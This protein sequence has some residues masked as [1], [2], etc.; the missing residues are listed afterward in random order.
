MICPSCGRSVPDGSRYCSGCG[1][2]L[3][4]FQNGF[5]CLRCGARMTTSKGICPQCGAASTSASSSSSS[6]AARVSAYSAASSVSGAAASAFTA[7]SEDSVTAAVSASADSASSSSAGFCVDT[8]YGSV[9]ANASVSS[10]GAAPKGFQNSGSRKTQIFCHSRLSSG[11]GSPL[12]EDFQEKLMNQI[13]NARQNYSAKGSNSGNG[14]FAFESRSGNGQSNFR[15][16]DNNGNA[17]NGG[18]LPEGFWENFGNMFKTLFP[19]N[20]NSSAARPSSE[21]RQQRSRFNSAGSEKFS[22]RFRDNVR[23]SFQD[24]SQPDNSRNRGGGNTRDYARAEPEDS[25]DDVFQI[26]E[27]ELEKILRKYEI[28]KEE[29]EEM[30]RQ[31]EIPEEELEEM[32]RQDEIPEEEL[33]EMLRQDEIP[34]EELEEMLHQD[35]ISKEELEELLRQGN[36]EIRRYFNEMKGSGNTAGFDRDHNARGYADNYADDY[37]DDYPKNR[38]GN[39]ASGGRHESRQKKDHAGNTRGFTYWETEELRKLNHS[40]DTAQIIMVLHIIFIFVGLYFSA[41]SLGYLAFTAPSKIRQAEYFL[42][43]CGYPESV[44]LCRR[45]LKTMIFFKIVSV[46]MALGLIVMIVISVAGALKIQDYSPDTVSRLFLFL[47]VF[48]LISLPFQVRSFMTFSGI[49]K[50]LKN[51]TPPK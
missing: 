14:S 8:Q 30:L 23:N 4:H 32:L 18:E 37:R 10:S 42:E 17:N 41:L 28:P 47:F 7:A 2:D 3:R 19:Q 50:D 48:W 31:D 5:F 27:E 34:E 51:L 44:R 39:Y 35:K 12:P 25:F 38:A 1:F 21:N 46:V 9:R 11:D 40:L 33:E 26:P 49:R 6:S 36:E 20:N 29:M 13:R 22:G 45:E 16:S 24:F 15:F 43:K